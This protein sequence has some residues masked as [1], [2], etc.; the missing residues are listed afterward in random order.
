M[1]G[2]CFLAF[3]LILICAVGVV[4]LDPNVD[5]SRLDCPVSCI[6]MIYMTVVDFFLLV[7]AV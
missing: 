1:G 5:I 4:M 3:R 6:A 2:F 7:L